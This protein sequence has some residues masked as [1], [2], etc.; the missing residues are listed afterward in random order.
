[1]EEIME[2][3]NSRSLRV[4]ERMGNEVQSLTESIREMTNKQD[5]M[6]SQQRESVNAIEHFAVSMTNILEKTLCGGDSPRHTQRE[7]ARQQEA[8]RSKS[9]LRGRHG[10]SSWSL[11]DYNQDL[12]G[13]GGEAASNLGFDSRG[14]S[15]WL[16]QNGNR[17][18]YISTPRRDSY[19]PPFIPFDSNYQ[20]PFERSFDNRGK[21]HEI[22][23][24]KLPTFDGTGDW[25]GFMLPFKRASKRYQWS[26]E[27]KMDRFVECFRGHASKFITT[28]PLSVQENFDRLAKMMEDRFNRKDP[29][30]RSRKRLEDL[31]QKGET[32]DE[33]AEEA[34]R[35]VARA[36]P[37]VAIELQEELAAEAFLKGY[38]NSRVGYEALNKAPKTVSEA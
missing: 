2:T 26:D 30:T 34:R 16:T 18:P 19:C 31:R 4:M 37:T 22:P 28:L 10:D 23:H 6:M 36:F 24:Q 25:I 35:L 20:R 12:D 9:P 5:E 33:C 21:K 17:R 3:L 32:D 1:M 7:D 8:R 38:R 11:N 14:D 15:P 13:F 27:E 29:P